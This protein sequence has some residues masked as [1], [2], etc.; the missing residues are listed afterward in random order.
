MKFME[1]FIFLKAADVLF[2]KQK[3]SITNSSGLSKEEVD[4]MV[5]EAQLHEADDKKRRE[6]ID[7]RNNLDNMITQIEKT[8]QENKEKLP[9]ADV[10]ATEKALEEAKKSC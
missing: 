1:L 5:K 4:R 8:L 9:M 7:K 2:P 10:S 6:T 3:I